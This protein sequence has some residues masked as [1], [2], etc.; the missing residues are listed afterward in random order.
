MF[1]F[2][3]LVT[4]HDLRITIIDTGELLM[5]HGRN[6]FHV[7]KMAACDIAPVLNVVSFRDHW[8]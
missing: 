8:E 1:P 6:I 3:A 4:L 5:E 2:N 7:T